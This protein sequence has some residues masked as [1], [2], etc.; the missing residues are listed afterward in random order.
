[1]PELLALSDRILVLREGR[2]TALLPRE[3]FAA[4]AILDYESP[5]GD[6]QEAFRVTT[7]DALR[8]ATT[9]H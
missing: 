8:S 6:V 3:E 7:S 2:P 4:D 5:G 9:Q 1:M